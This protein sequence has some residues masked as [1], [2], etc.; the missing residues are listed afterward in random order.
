LVILFEVFV[1]NFEELNTLADAS[2]L[3][4]LERRSK[5]VKLWSWRSNNKYKFYWSWRMLLLLAKHFGLRDTL[6]V[7]CTW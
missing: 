2:Y 3:S 6:N 1:I 7:H 5:R 4:L